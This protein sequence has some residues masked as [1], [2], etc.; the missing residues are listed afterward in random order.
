LLQERLG[1]CRPNLALAVL[2]AIYLL[3][4]C[5]HL[6][7]PGLYYDEVLFANAALGNIDHSSV[8]YE[9]KLGC[10]HLPLML[11]SYIGALKAYPFAPIFCL[12][13]PFQFAYPSS[14]SV[15]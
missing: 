4:S 5:L 7:R 11:M 8:Q 2:L 14:S 15:S 3:F 12:P 1:R 9:W 10:I 13:R 6:K